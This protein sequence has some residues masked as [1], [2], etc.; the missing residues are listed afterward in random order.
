MKLLNKTLRLYI[1]YAALILLIAV[2]VFYF[3]IKNIVIEDVDESM[4]AQ[5][6]ALIKKLEMQ[7]NGA[8]LY[9]EINSTDFE[10]KLLASYSK[11]D[12]FFITYK[13]D[14]ISK[15]ILPY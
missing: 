7:T 8:Q 5:K 10:L 6:S 4:M 2:P 1:V 11:F 9:P 3:A 15:E 14:S 12:T 13:Y